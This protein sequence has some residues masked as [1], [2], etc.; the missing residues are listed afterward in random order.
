MRLIGILLVSALALASCQQ[1]VAAKSRGVLQS[2]QK[3]PYLT[4]SPKVTG[5]LILP[6]ADKSAAAAIAD[7]DNGGIVDELGDKVE[8]S[9]PPILFDFDGTALPK[10]SDSLLGQVASAL[11]RHDNWTLVI[12]GHT[13]QQGSE[14]YNRVL[15]ERRALMVQ[16]RLIKL[17]PWTKD[18]IRSVA[19]GAERPAIEAYDPASQARNR[20]VEFEFWAR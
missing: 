16:E 11:G 13:D 12:G 17:H 14:E 4:T 5:H 6:R 9:F 3:T 1:G 19:W 10:G 2:S 20:R 18:R 7:S 8:T 15:S